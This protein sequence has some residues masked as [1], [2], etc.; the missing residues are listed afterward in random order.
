MW[1]ILVVGG[2]DGRRD[3]VMGRGGTDAVGAAVYIY[4]RR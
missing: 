3:I 2:N 4:R 1:G